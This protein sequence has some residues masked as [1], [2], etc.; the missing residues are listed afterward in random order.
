[1]VQA[2]VPVKHADGSLST[3]TYRIALGAA[4][5]P[6]ALDAKIEAMFKAKGPID[7]NVMAALKDDIIW[8]QDS[9]DTG[10]WRA[11]ADFTKW[12]KT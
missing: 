6:A 12:A 2:A 10:D 8:Q 7:E 3:T 5:D 11:A 4:G 9:T 1:V